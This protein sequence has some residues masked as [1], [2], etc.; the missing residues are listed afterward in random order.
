MFPRRGETSRERQHHPRHNH[1]LHA[2]LVRD[3]WCDAMPRR[4]RGGSSS[5]ALPEVVDLLSDDED[6][7]DATAEPQSNRRKSRRLEH[8]ERP[9][10]DAPLLCFPSAA[11]KESISVTYGDLRRLRPSTA[12]GL[13]SII[14]FPEQLLLNDTLVDVRTRFGTSTSTRVFVCACVCVRVRACACVCVRVRAC[15]CVCMHACLHA[16]VRALVLT[17]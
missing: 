14:C 12:Y 9:A 10:S 15:A 3:E 1:G 8:Q 4:P 5:D 13:S 6:A 16:C 7:A 11:A 17:E 2:E